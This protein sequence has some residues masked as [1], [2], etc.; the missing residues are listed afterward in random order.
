MITGFHFKTGFRRLMAIFLLILF[1]SLHN[2]LYAQSV[3]SLNVRAQQ[4]AQ[5]SI[6]RNS[7]TWDNMQELKKLGSTSP[8]TAIQSQQ[9]I[10]QVNNQVMQ[11]MYYNPPPTQQ[12]IQEALRQQAQGQPP[13]L[14]EEEKRAAEIRIIL[15]EA[16]RSE[17]VSKVDYWNTAEFAASE[18]AYDTA[19]DK[20]QQQLTTNNL[21][22]KDAYFEIEN[23]YG[24]TFL[25][26]PEYDGQ[27]E[28]SANFI[29]RWMLENHLDTKSNLA[30]NFAI[31]KF[32]SDT[33]SI[34]KHLLELPNV[35]P[36]THLPFYYDYEDYKAEKDYRSYNVTKT[37]ATGNG[38][39]HTLTLI[40]AI[41]AEALGATC[42]LTEAPIHQFIKYPDNQGNLH[43]YEVTSNWQITDQWYKDYLYVN[44][45]AEKNK[46]YLCPLTKQQIIAGAIIDLACSY[47]QK[48]GVGDGQF[49]NKCVDAAMSYFPNKDANIYGWLLR[50]KVIA[51]KLYRVLTQNGARTITQAEQIPEAKA[52]M[53]NINT[54]NTKIA[55]L[56]YVEIPDE[57]YDYMVQN[58]DNKGK[59]QALKQMDNLQKRNLFIPKTKIR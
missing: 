23:T 28:K 59:I 51:V 46:I 52:L 1:S 27:I 54:L 8:T 47:K 39:C 20:L 38:Q 33:L 32:M 19:L 7:P 26:K 34:G 21:S 15:S 25:T 10:N 45:V 56:G 4:Q 42:Y 3:D 5:Y 29:I 13:S 44:S 58:Q 49:I 50:E 43:N 53:D 41:L 30:V 36:E 55:S 11:A 24:N 22:I 40:Y 17:P 57:A 48:L 12:Q 16:H 6:Y 18:T 9:I 14:T 35:K 37:F 2:S 31:Q